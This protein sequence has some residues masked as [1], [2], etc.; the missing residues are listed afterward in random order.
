VLRSLSVGAFVVILGIVAFTAASLWLFRRADQFGFRNRWVVAAIA[1]SA[2]VARTLLGRPRILLL[3][4]LLSLVKIGLTGISYWLVLGGL[5]AAAPPLMN[6]TIA[7]ISSGLVAYL[8]LSANG[9]GTVEMAGTGLFGEIGVSLAV[10]LSMYV[11]LR[12]VNIL[13]A[14]V[15]AA[16][17]MPDLLSHRRR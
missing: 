5:I 2:E 11:L 10:V 1:T 16:L 6:V 7:A 15:P 14:W 9:I 13:L 12:L 17:L 4:L 3:N 8:P